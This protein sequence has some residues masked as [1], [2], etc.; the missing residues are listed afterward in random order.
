LV[1]N[2][3]HKRLIRW[4]AAWI[5]LIALLTTAC[6]RPDTLSSIKAEGVLHVITRNAPS[7]Y[8]EGRDGP[9]GYDYELARMFADELGVELRVREARDNTEVISVLD[10]NYAHIGMAGIARRPGLEEKY[11]VINSGLEAESVIIYRRNSP[12]PETIEDLIGSTV[13]VVADSNHEYQLQA[14][15][16][17]YP[18]LQ[19]EA[20]SGL[21][22]AGL[23]ERVQSGDIRVALIASNELALN[24]VFY[25]RVKESF[26]LG[27]PE[28]LTWLLPGQQ[29]DSLKKRMQAFLQKQRENGT[30]AQLSE[31]FYG[32]LDRLTYVGARTFTHHVENRLP[33]YRDLFQ[34][35]AREH[36]LDWRL[37]AAI[38]YQESH[39]RPNAVSPTGVRGLMMLTRTTARYVGINNRLDPVDSIRGGA[40]YFTMVYRQI[41]DDIPEPDRTW[42]ALASYNVGYGH[43][44]DARRLAEDAGKNPD[45]WMDVKEFLP[46]LAQKEWY[47]RTR[48]GYARGHEPVI[49]VQNIRRY[50]DVLAWM[51]E[52]PETLEPLPEHQFADIE[53]TPAAGQADDDAPR[54]P[55]IEARNEAR[56]PDDFGMIPPVL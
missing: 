31:R 12:R 22:A 26:T 17:D 20:H 8:F 14:L 56:L 38:G 45:R 27:E 16:D 37:L 47:S 55:T 2:L 7:I 24:H 44:E 53:G 19:W 36:G 10:R 23:M 40:R 28:K 9:T 48:F 49:Y 52:D 32:H 1:L 29:D 41:P 33:K 5:L 13:H 39:W 50:Y 42:F 6:S 11:H 18:E 51:T 3:T 35:T 43:L 21:D 25:P 34:E 46:L 54:K 30:L 15:S 4:K